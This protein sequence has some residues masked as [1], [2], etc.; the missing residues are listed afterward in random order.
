MKNIRSL[1]AALFIGC[2]M[3]AFGCG[4]PRRGEPLTGVAMLPGDGTQQGRLVFQQHCHQCH[5]GG[6]GGLGPALNNKPAPVWLMKTQ[7]RVGLGAMPGFGEDQ[8]T[9]EELDDLMA[10][11][12]ALRHSGRE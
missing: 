3:L 2:L 9:D 12:M 5:P 7:V 8:I 1:K 11:V 6:E 4:S 10:Y